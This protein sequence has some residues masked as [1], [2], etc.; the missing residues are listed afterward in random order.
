MQFYSVRFFRTSALHA[1]CKVK[2]Y[3][4][5]TRGLKKCL[6]PKCYVLKIFYIILKYDFVLLENV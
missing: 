2:H 3:C 5:Y 1:A 6:N 4:I